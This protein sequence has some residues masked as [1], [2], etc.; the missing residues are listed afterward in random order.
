MSHN[1][2]SFWCQ[3]C[4]RNVMHMVYYW[5]WFEGEIRRFMLINKHRCINKLIFWHV[6]YLNKNWGSSMTGHCELHS[7]IMLF[8][9]DHT[10]A[11]THTHI[12]IYSHGYWLKGCLAS[13]ALNK[14]VKVSGVKEKELIEEYWAVCEHGFKAKLITR[15]WEI[16]RDHEN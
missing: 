13:C 5:R 8:W 15:C 16:E 10:H 4:D 9:V 11:H 3:K 14:I 1:K 6:Y 12:Y 7:Y 2:P